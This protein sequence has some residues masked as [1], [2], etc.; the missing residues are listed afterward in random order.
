MSRKTLLAIS[1]VV[2]LVVAMSI[3]ILKR[4]APPKVSDA[5]PTP[6][7]QMRNP[8][9][10]ANVT[11]S[12]SGMPVAQVIDVYEGWAKEK[13]AP[14]KAGWPAGIVHVIAPH[15]LTTN[16]ALR[17]IEAALKEQSGIVIRRGGDG[18]LSAET[19]SPAG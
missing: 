8:A 5:V 1:V 12:F 11:F 14:P 6:D 15:P 18:S 3:A 13:V 4:R 19:A 16:E 10:V 17:S 2:I 9:D 7:G